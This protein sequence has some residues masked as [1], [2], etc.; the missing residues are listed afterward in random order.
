LTPEQMKKYE[1]AM[2]EARKKAAE[3]PGEKTGEKPAGP[4]PTKSPG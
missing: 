2:A 3:K 4:A 1:A